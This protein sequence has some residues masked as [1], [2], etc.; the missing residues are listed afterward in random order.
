MKTDLNR[1][2]IDVGSETFT[3]LNTNDSLELIEVLF[4]LTRCIRIGSFDRH[5]LIVLAANFVTCPEIDRTDCNT[6]WYIQI[7]DVQ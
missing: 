6:L 7:C 2:S 4:R 5:L 3:K 1:K